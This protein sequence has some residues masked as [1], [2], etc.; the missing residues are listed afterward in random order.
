[1]GIRSTKFA[2]RSKADF[3]ADAKELM[4]KIKTRHSSSADIET[5]ICSHPLAGPAWR[6]AIA[7]LMAGAD[8]G[9]ED[10]S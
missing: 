5:F 6:D 4:A 7:E 8:I 10:K 2:P 9:R 3:L 1:M